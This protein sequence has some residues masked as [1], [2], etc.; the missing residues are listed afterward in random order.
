MTNSAKAGA[1]GIRSAFS[2]LGGIIAGA[3]SVGA[4]V[5]FGKKLLGL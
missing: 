5:A 4:V 1:G 2:G 3:L